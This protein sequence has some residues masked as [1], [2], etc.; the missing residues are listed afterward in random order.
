MRDRN[1]HFNAIANRVI[2]SQRDS[3]TKSKSSHND[4]KNIVNIIETLTQSST[5][6]KKMSKDY[7]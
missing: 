3:D 4:E 2:A 5:L 1:A 6:E 7:S